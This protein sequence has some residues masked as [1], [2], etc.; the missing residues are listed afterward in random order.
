MILN[1]NIRVGKRKKTVNRKKYPK[2]VLRNMVRGY[3]FMF[4]FSHKNSDRI[5]K[6][7]KPSL[8]LKGVEIPFTEHIIYTILGVANKN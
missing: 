1:L 2:C 3:S 6:C 7:Q 8:L 5:L 4:G